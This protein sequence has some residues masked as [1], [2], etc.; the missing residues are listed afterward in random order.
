MARW[1]RGLVVLAAVVGVAGGALARSPLR[2]AEWSSDPAV[3][4]ALLAAGAPAGALAAHDSALEHAVQLL[5]RAGRDVV[6]LLLFHGADP[7]AALPMVQWSPFLSGE[8]RRA[9]DHRLRTYGMATQENFAR[10]RA[11]RR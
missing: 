7:Y 5:F 3:V 9:L 2:E 4:E 11:F 6:E 8:E 1:T 10:P